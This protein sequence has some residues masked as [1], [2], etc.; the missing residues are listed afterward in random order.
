MA[1]SEDVQQ[2]I[3]I[4]EEED[5]GALA[6]ELLTEISRGRPV[7]KRLEQDSPE[8]DTGG[9][10]N[11]ETVLVRVPFADDEQLPESVQFLRLRLVEPVRAFAE[12]ER[13]AGSLAGA[14]AVRIRFVD[15]ENR[16]ET[17][18]M[19]R[20]DL[21]DSSLADKLDALLTRLPDMRSPPAGTEV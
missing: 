1:I 14:Q 5:F 4:L 19:S 20:R 12:A 7:E 9:A 8:G 21:G 11:D 13:I 16:Q 2:I 10:E 6:G 15:P 3:R 17:E 18:P